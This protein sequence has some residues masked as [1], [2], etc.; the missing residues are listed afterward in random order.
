[1]TEHFEWE[2]AF[3]IRVEAMNDEHKKLIAIMNRLA[4]ESDAK[5]PRGR[6]SRSLKELGDYTKIH[7][8]H[9]EAYME[10]IAYPKLAI[11]R[12]VHKQLLQQFSGFVEQF[13][14]GNGTISE[15]FFH[16]LKRWL[17]A[18]I[19]HIDGQYGEFSQTVRKSA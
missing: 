9:E 16:F 6:L 3:D 5:A 13:E 19:K 18:H 4:D 8:A 15:D 2:P 11:H 12:G 17:I 7:F 14:A 10:S 1:M